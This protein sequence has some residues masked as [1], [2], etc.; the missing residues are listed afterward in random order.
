MRKV[1]LFIICCI[2]ITQIIAQED[3]RIIDKII[4]Q[5]GDEYILLSEIEA[6]YGYESERAGGLPPEARCQILEGLMMKKLLITQAQLD[7]VIVEAEQVEQELDGRIEYILGLMNNDVQQMEEYYGKTLN[8]IRTQFRS[9]LRDQLIEQKMRQ[10]ILADVEITPSEVK[11]FYNQIPRDS[12]PYFNS[13][14][15]VSEIVIIPKVNQEEREKA[16]AQLQDVRKRILVDGESFAELAGIYS[17]DPGSASRG[18]DLGMQRRGTFVPEFEAAAYNLEE[19][20]ISEI[21]ETEFGFHIIQLI[22][23]RGNMVHTKHILVK[24]NITINDLE[25][26]EERLDS[27]KGVIESDS[28]PFEAAVKAFSSDKVQ[29]FNNGGRIIN[30]KTGDTFFE[31]ADLETDIFFTIDTMEIGEISSPL[32]FQMEDGSYAFRIIRLNSMTDP[33]VANLKQDYTKIKNAAIEQQKSRFLN[34]WLEQRITSTFVEIDPNFLKMCGNL[35]RWIGDKVAR[36][37]K[38][39]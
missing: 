30:N 14:V 26:A 9:E 16:L 2:A 24:P 4:A 21:V 32:R 27:I 23:R 35:Q 6:Q 25:L 33:H 38:R 3:S 11:N 13:E 31:T 22:E 1:Y 12:L 34:E 18:G 28:I 15:E 5:V 19:G 29:S 8:E 17:D 39:T 37:N 36:D 7:S 10:S 20:E